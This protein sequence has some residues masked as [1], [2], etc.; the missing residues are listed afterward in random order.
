M[1]GN[2]VFPC[3]FIEMRTRYMAMVGGHPII[4]MWPYSRNTSASEKNV[5]AKYRSEMEPG[6]LSVTSEAGLRSCS[7]QI[8]Y[9]ELVCG[10]DGVTT[11]TQEQTQ[12][13]VFRLIHA[14]FSSS[15]NEGGLC[16]FIDS[17]QVELVGS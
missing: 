6:S 11:T 12:S 17:A 16:R 3:S 2:S 8:R 5:T 7:D 14:V 1:D 13:T 10:D 9:L 4:P 15:M